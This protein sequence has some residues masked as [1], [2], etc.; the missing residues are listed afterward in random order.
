MGIA[1][2]RYAGGH[3]QSR[4]LAS[5]SRRRKSPAFGSE[6]NALSADADKRTGNKAL[7]RA[8]L[9]R[10]LT[11]RIRIDVRTS[12]TVHWGNRRC[13]RL[14]SAN[15]SREEP[16]DEAISIIAFQKQPL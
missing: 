10:Q 16:G 12:S 14:R 9:I 2:A 1:A 5:R 3:A 7:A 4:A 6:E 11:H 13:V 8:I 15:S